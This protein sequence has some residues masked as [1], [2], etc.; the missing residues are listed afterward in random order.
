M[1]FADTL[2]AGAKNLLD[3]ITNPDYPLASPRALKPIFDVV[4]ELLDRIA[5]GGDSEGDVVVLDE[6]GKVPTAL[7]D[8]GEAAGKLVVLDENGKVP[9]D[10][11]T[12]PANSGGG[13]GLA[14][15]TVT[16][17]TDSIDE[18]N[19]A[20]LTLALPGGVSRFYIVGATLERAG[21]ASALAG[22]TLYPTAAR[23]S[24]AALLFGD[25]FS[26]VDMPGPVNGPYDTTGGNVARSGIAMASEAEFAYLT[27]HNRDF[28]NAGSFTVTITCLPVAE[29]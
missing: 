14:L 26:G 27:V 2:R 5:A 25:A 21:G 24:G 22:V 3:I 19:A 1:A 20:D 9:A 17:T 4:A 23:S 6:N 8:T 13:G 10:L 12:L 11:I 28:S 15:F 18:S 29:E 16:G 7:L